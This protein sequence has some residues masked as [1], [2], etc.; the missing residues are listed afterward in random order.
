ME[1]RMKKFTKISL[2]ASGV[3]VA[4]GLILGIIYTIFGGGLK[5]ILQMAEDGE[6]DRGFLHISP[7]GIY[8]SDDHHSSETSH[9]SGVSHDSE[10]QHGS[11]TGRNGS[12]GDYAGDYAYVWSAADISGIKLDAAAVKVRFEESDTDEVR[13][14]LV[15]GDEDDFDVKL[16]NGELEIEY[17]PDDINISID[18]LGTSG[19]KREILVEL[20]PDFALDELE[21]DLDAAIVDADVS[22]IKVARM[23]IDAD[24]A[25]ITIAA[26]MA[27]ILK[28]DVDAGNVE[29]TTSVGSSADIEADMG[30]V[31]LALQ[32]DES[33]YNYEISCGL[34]SVQIG[35]SDYSGLDN[36]RSV[37]NNGAFGQIKINCDMG[38]VKVSF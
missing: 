12:S 21:F 30:N 38:S 4:L 37:I 36:E 15:S 23:K 5:T 33:D 18:I 10:R 20:P 28:I 8:L 14:T 25:D 1:K 17:E 16:D 2:I 27:D 34:G 32:G 13:V 26:G 29:V 19:Y 6:L 22:D 9:S 3:L 24:A 11:F 31:L 35:G 7:S